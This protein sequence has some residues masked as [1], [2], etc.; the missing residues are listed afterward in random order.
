MGR[1]VAGFFHSTLLSGRFIMLSVAVILFHCRVYLLILLLMDIRTVFRFGLL[2]YYC[3][4]HFVALSTHCCW[5][6]RQEWKLVM[7]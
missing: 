2:I 5:V 7:G 4:S 6:Y 3:S 1:F